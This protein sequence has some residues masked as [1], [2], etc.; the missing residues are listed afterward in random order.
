M[1]GKTNAGGGSAAL[2]FKIVGGTTAPSSPSEN[3]IWVNTSTPISD[4]VFSASQPSSP[5]AGLVW[6]RTSASSTAP[7]SAL[8]RKVLMVYPAS[9]KQ[10]VNGAWV[11]VT[12]QSYQNNGWVLWSLILY[13]PGNVHTETT[14]GYEGKAIRFAESYGG[15][16]IKVKAPT[17]TPGS[18][19]LVISLQNNPYGEN[20]SGSALTVNK[21]DLTAYQKIVFEGSF[22]FENGVDSMRFYVSESNTAYNPAAEVIVQGNNVPSSGKVTVN[23]AGLSGEYYVGVNILTGDAEQ[24]T[25]SVTLTRIACE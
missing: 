11:D 12:A 13:E 24:I 18:S 3:T 19:S 5:A 16:T 17:V 2:N 14:G 15:Y 25:N 6:I 1:Y 7:F 21:I 22:S 4:W 9:A 23:V 20:N 8:K 10:Y